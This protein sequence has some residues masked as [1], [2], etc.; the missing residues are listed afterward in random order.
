MTQRLEDNPEIEQRE[1]AP[2]LNVTKLPFS[3]AK[4]YDRILEALKLTF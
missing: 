1:L 4:A 3:V 2:A